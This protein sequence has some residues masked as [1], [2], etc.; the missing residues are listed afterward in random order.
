MLTGTFKQQNQQTKEE[1]VGEIWDASIQE[2]HGQGQ[3]DYVFHNGEEEI[4]VVMQWSA[5]QIW[6]KESGQHFQLYLELWY[7]HEGEGYVKTPEGMML[8][9]TR[10]QSFDYQ[11]D[12]EQHTCQLCYDLLQAGDAMGS[13]LT[14][15]LAK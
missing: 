7:G 1:M 4:Q 9:T 2:A 13:K 14:I 6:I 3:L 5:E 8:L 12:E 11:E 10:L 15:Q